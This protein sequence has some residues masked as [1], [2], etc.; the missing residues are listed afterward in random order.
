MRVK[1]LT[2]TALLAWV[3]LLPD[4]ASAGGRGAPVGKRQDPACKA[5]EFRVLLDVGHSAEVPGAMSARGVPEYE[6][7]LRLAKNIEGALR[8]AGFRSTQL[9]ITPGPARKGLYAR[10][11]RANTW[12]ADLVISVHHDSVPEWFLESWVHEGRPSRFSDRFAGH[13]LF[14]SFQN[15]EAEAS[16]L[17]ARLLGRELKGKGLR[18]TPHYTFP[19]MDWKQRDLVDAETGVYRYDQLIVLRDSKAP[20]VLLEA[21]SIINRAEELAMSSP[22]R[23]TAIA[24]AATAAVRQFCAARAQ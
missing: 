15:Q 18:Y 2:I 12:P 14:V 13:S 21:G 9:L 7:N 5:A 17:F 22:E 19:V 3:L 20:T 10:V 23:H 8:R 16:V 4:G 24:A 6:F 1:R 11:A